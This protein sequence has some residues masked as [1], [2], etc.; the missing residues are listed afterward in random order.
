MLKAIADQNFK[1]SKHPSS[2]LFLQL[3]ILPDLPLL[4]ISLQS[5]F[6]LIWAAAEGVTGKFGTADH[7]SKKK[8]QTSMKLSRGQHW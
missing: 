2:G 6:T 7:I 8:E 1:T 5:P 3:P 4:K